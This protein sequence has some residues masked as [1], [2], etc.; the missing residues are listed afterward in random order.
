MDGEYYH[1]IWQSCTNDPHKLHLENCFG[2]R[3][4]M[5]LARDFKID[6][7]RPVVKAIQD[8]RFILRDANEQYYLWD[9]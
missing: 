6:G 7:L 2:S 4:D 9:A 8:D 1:S 3:L 5:N